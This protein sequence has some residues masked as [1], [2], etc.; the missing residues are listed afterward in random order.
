MKVLIL[1]NLSL[2]D[3]KHIRI[4]IWYNKVSIASEVWD[5]FRTV[6]E[7]VSKYTAMSPLEFFT[8]HNIVME[9]KVGFVWIRK[10][11]L[12]FLLH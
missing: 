8:Q 5:T 7:S 2:I 12:Q 3:N 4:Y 9:E 6:P 11:S 10:A 1:R